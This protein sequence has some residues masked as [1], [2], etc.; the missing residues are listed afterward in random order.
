M[1]YKILPIAAPELQTS[2]FRSNH[3]ANRVTTTGFEMKYQN[4]IVTMEASYGN[5]V[6]ENYT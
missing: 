1:L 6:K 4:K 5:Q 2:G 3:S